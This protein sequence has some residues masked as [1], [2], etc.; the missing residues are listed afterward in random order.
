MGRPGIRIKGLEVKGLGPIQDFALPQD[1]LGWKGEMPDLVMLGG[2]NGSGKSTLLDG[3]YNGLHQCLVKSGE[4]GIN[5][6]IPSATQ[7]HLVPT[8]FKVSL[9]NGIGQDC[10]LTFGANANHP[11][12]KPFDQ[13]EIFRAGLDEARNQLDGEYPR[14]FLLPSQRRLVIPNTKRKHAGMGIRALPLVDRWHEPESWDA[15]FEAFLYDLRW[16]DLNAKEQGQSSQLF[17]NYTVDLPEI[18]QGRKRFSWDGGVLQ[19]QLNNGTRH[20]LEALSSGEQQILL[21]MGEL[22]RRWS[23]GSLVLIDEP[24]L[25]LHQ[26]MQEALLSAMRSL[27]AERGGQLWLATQSNHLFDMAKP[28]EAALLGKGLLW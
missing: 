22:R 13:A 18:T 5:L 28:G 8:L 23:P 19:I 25:H 15:S 10:D 2:I 27:L 17:K 24:E 12:G 20:P 26:S 16:Q 3:I 14:V 6:A 7:G 1:G 4:D 11:L 9:E 21:M